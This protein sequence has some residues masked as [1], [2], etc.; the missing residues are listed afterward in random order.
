MIYCQLYY[1]KNKQYIQIK[2]CLN[3]HRNICITQLSNTIEAKYYQKNGI[4]QA[5]GLASSTSS[6]DV[7]SLSFGVTK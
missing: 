3:T 4:S 6:S 5:K 2:T 1:T 7:S